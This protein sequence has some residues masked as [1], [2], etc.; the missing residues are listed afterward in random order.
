MTIFENVRIINFNPPSVS[1]PADVAVPGPGEAGAGTIAEIGRGLAAKHAGA[2]LLKGAWLSPGLVCSH[3]HLYSA[4]ARGLTVAIAPSKD[5]AQILKNLWW[6]LDRAIDLPILE[7][8]ALA[9][10]SDAALCGVTSVVDHHAGPE[11]ID[12]S[13]SVIRKAYE[14]IGLRG[15]LCYET[16]DR[17]GLEGARAGIRENLRFAREIDEARKAAGSATPGRIPA[18]PPLVDAMIGAHAG[19]TVG[20]ETLEALSDAL[21]ESGRGLHIHLAEDRFDAVDSRHRFDADPVERFDRAGCLGPRTLIGHGLWLSESEV[22]L[23][24][25]RGCYL[26]HNARSNMNNAVGYNGLL[27]RHER[28]V[29]GTDGMG[30]DML[31]E[32]K[33]A[34]F[35]HRESGGPWWP[36]EFLAALDRGNRIIETYFGGNHGKVEAGAAADL[37]L[38]DY[39]AP[40]PLEGDNIAGHMAFGL[41]S[42]SVRSV[43]VGGK[44]VV[45]EGKPLFDGEGIAAKARS[46]AARLWKRMEERT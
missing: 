10:L 31:E 2:R 18:A 33:F 21:R 39:E 1:P 8:S 5:F 16:S 17:N 44:F 25:A 20:N 35:R 9:G 4:L 42:R 26:A 37:V 29:L 28:V 46:E 32:F 40:T 45:E 23:M 12:G 6:R 34:V 41:S 36:P 13:L 43:M 27:H 22:E 38:W 30:A 11:A 14:E 19:F 24:N 7:A 15:I 3:T